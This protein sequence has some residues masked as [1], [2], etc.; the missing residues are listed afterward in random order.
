M[1]FKI[2]NR[3]VKYKCTDRIVVTPKNLNII[4]SVQQILWF[5][6][7][8]S[9]G[10]DIG[11]VVTKKCKV[12]G[13]NSNTFKIIL[14]QG[15][16]RQI[17]RMSLAF[18]YRVI[19]LERIRILNIKIDGIEPGKYRNLN[20]KFPNLTENEKKLCAL[21]RLDMNTKDIASITRQNPSSIEVARTRL[22]KKLN[23]SNTDISLNNFLAK[24]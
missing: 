20:E 6:K 18:G 21:L 22:R 8:I 17:R 14:T 23:I 15:L 3:N 7:N 10:V 12:E 24:L 9:N 13:I 5:L 4:I 1:V 16:N 2:G 11:G 19:K